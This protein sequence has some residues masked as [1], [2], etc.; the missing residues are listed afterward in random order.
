M[1]Y[2]TVVEQPTSAA[3]RRMVSASGP[4]ASSSRLATSSTSRRTAWRPAAYAWP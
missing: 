3:I 4:S 1:V 2:R